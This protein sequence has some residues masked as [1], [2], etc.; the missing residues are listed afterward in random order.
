[1]TLE[2]LLPF[3]DDPPESLQD[4]AQGLLIASHFNGIPAG[5]A[6]QRK[7]T[8][9]TFRFPELMLDAESMSPLDWE[10]GGVGW[11][12]DLVHRCSGSRR[13]KAEKMGPKKHGGRED[14]VGRQQDQV[15]IIPGR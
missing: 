9:E 13:P 15:G 1:V 10:P 7:K 6:H 2:D 12:N 8:V 4:T 11:G 3:V 14:T 5:S